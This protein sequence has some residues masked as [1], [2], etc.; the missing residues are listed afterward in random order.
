MRH[1]AIHPLSSWIVKL[2]IFKGGTEWGQS[3]LLQN[4]PVWH[5][6]YLNKTAD[7]KSSKN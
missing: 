2:P 6:D 7:R 5:I 3:S 1:G 4:M